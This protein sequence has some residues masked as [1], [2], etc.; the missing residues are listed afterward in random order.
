MLSTYWARYSCHEV[1]FFDFPRRVT[2]SIF[3]QI[4]EIEEE[5]PIFFPFDS[6]S[7]IFSRV[8]VDFPVL[9]FLFVKFHF[10]FGI[11]PQAKGA[12]ALHL[13]SLVLCCAPSVSLITCFRSTIQLFIWKLLDFNIYC[14]YHQYNHVVIFSILQSWFSSSI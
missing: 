3:L 4:F 12:Q 1:H 10:P 14:R 6:P 5:A 9:G 11:F 2:S 7:P 8:S 13:I